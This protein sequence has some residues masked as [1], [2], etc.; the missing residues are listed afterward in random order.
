MEDWQSLAYRGSL[1]N[2]CGVKTTVGSNPTSSARNCRIVTRL[3]PYYY[4]YS[5][6]ILWKMENV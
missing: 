6:E 5:K 3:P 4:I 2:C 1:E